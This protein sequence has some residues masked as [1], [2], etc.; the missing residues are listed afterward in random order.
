MISLRDRDDT[1]WTPDGSIGQGD[2][3]YS[4]LDGTLSGWRRC[5]VDA[6]YGPVIEIAE[7]TSGSDGGA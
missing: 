4:A 3:T 7:P 5:E 2:V 1:I 6:Q